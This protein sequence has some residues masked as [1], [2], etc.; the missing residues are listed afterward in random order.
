MKTLLTALVLCSVTFGGSAPSFRGELLTG[1]KTSLDQ[2]V[3]PNR[4]VLLSFWAT[5]C[6]PCIQEL[7]EVTTKLA[8]EPSLPIDLVTVNIDREDRSEVPALMKQ[9]G[10]SF[11][12]VMDPTSE[13]FG[14]YQ[15]AGTP[16]FTVLISPKKEILH[17]FSGYHDTMFSTVKK[18]AEAFQKAGS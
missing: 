7:K 5:W 1:G 13:I 11:P 4:L 8:A 18:T 16:P 6:I 2:I 9:L 14:K 17:T 3:K 15:K 10:F 12:V